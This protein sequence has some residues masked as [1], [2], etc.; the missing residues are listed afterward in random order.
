MDSLELD[1]HVAPRGSYELADMI[2]CKPFFNLFFP[3]VLYNSFAEPME[4][5]ILKNL[6]KMVSL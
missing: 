5:H 4:K 1:S 2:L 3:S 6:N